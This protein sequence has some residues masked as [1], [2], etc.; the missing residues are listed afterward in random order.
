MLKH[1]TA[2]E[3]LGTADF[4]SIQKPFEPSCHS[5]FPYI[6]II[7]KRYREIIRIRLCFTVSL[8]PSLSS[9][10][11]ALTLLLS[12]RVCVLCPL[13]WSPVS[14]MVPKMHCGFVGGICARACVCTCESEI[15][16]VWPGRGDAVILTHERFSISS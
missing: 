1:V 12:P 8:P 15:E 9:I 11:I 4:T 13:R 14:L 3:S 10:S 6:T 7:M 5:G 16:C 2:K